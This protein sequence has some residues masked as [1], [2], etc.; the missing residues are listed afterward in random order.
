M[1][2][3]GKEDST[4]NNRAEQSQSV[5]QAAHTVLPIILS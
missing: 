2:L 5:A 4:L 1:R 3:G